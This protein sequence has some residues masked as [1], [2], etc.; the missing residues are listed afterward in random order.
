MATGSYAQRNIIDNASNIYGMEGQAL[1]VAKLRQQKQ[2]AYPDY[3]PELFYLGIY[4]PA[5]QQVAITELS[6]L[7][8]GLQS[9]TLPLTEVDDYLI[10]L[11]EKE[12]LERMQVSYL[13]AKYQ[14]LTEVEIMP[15]VVVNPYTQGLKQLMLAFI[16]DE[17]TAADGLY[18][19]AIEDLS[20]I[21]YYW[22]EAQF[23]YAEFLHQQD[24]PQLT[25]QFNEVYQ[26]GFE[27]AKYYHFSYLQYRLITW[28]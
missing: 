24:L 20:H 1:F 26:Q 22:V 10:K 2:R 8:I 5:L 28:R 12:H 4:G 27:R 25:L 13:K 9:G 16:S 19:Q 14:P 23:F 15:L 7:T 18:Q 17:V 11:N 3:P 6:S 21:K